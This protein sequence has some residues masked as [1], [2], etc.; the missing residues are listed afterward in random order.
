MPD[1]V[2][3]YHP[4]GQ[5]A[6]VR[7]KTLSMWRRAGWRVEPID[8]TIVEPA[9]TTIVQPFQVTTWGRTATF[10]LDES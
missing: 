4:N 5:T 10:D 9:H 8:P 2:T 7:P 3:I 6:R 1:K